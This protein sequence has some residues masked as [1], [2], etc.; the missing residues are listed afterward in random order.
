MIAAVV[1]AA[2]LA[3]RM[4][5]RPK[6]LLQ[7]DRRDTFVTRIVRTFDVAGIADVVVVVGHEATHVAAAVKE[8]GLPARTVLNRD[9]Q[10]GQWSSLIAGINA[11]DRPDVEAVLLALVDAPLFA[12]STVRA[13]V[14]RFH[15]THAPVVRAVRGEEHGHP[16][17]I[18][19]ELF[20]LLR[21]ADPQTGA[22][23][24]VRG[25]ASAAGDVPV[26]DAGA[27]IDIDTPD[28]YAALP[29]LLLR[30]PR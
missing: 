28:E 18:A 23:P 13:V 16:V 29:D 19:R 27:F 12:E 24:I 14:E 3:S 7:L 6:A 11:V 17:L 8:S 9:Y 26:T 10:L 2:G 25:H 15:V 1:L 4:G 20:D 30:L 21:A 5:G 22:K